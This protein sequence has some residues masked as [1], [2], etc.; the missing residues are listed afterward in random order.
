MLPGTLAD[1]VNEADEFVIG[2]VAKELRKSLACVA[3]HTD[4]VP[5]Y[6]GSFESV[7]LLSADSHQ[8]RHFEWIWSMLHFSARLPRFPNEVGRRP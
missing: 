4:V 7:E 6:Q 8:G 1:L 5:C 2:P 3:R